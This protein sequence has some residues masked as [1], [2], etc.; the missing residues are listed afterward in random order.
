MNWNLAPASAGRTRAGRRTRV[1]RALVGVFLRPSSRAALL[2][3]VVLAFAS[4]SGPVRLLDAAEITLKNKL[5]LKGVAT[6]LKSLTVAEAKKKEDPDA[7]TI[8]P[9]L[10]ITTPLE[11]YFIPIRQQA[12][13]NNAVDLSK[14]DG[15]KVPQTKEKGG[16]QVIGAVHGYYEKP[17][18][19][20]SAGQRTL[21][22]EFEK[23]PSEV[24]QGVT[25]ITPDYIKI[26]AL[27]YLWETAMATSSM[28][29]ESLDAIIRKV[30]RQDNP[31]DRL[32]IATFYIQAGLY[33]SAERELEAIGKKF[34]TLSA[35]VKDVKVAL[36]QAF[37]QEILNEMKL[38]RAAGQ[39]QFVYDKSKAFPFENAGPTILR[40]VR[41]FTADYDKAHEKAEQ[42]IAQLGEL[43][44]QLKDDPRVKEIA[45]HRAEIYE[46]LNYSS[47]G[48]LE[49]YSKL[50]GDPLLKPDEKLALALSGWIVGS[51]NAVT[52]LDQALRFWQARIL[53]TEYLRTGPDADSER[54]AIL[55]KMEGLDGV[56]PERVAQMIPLL[57]PARD[58]AGAAPG[59]VVR[60]EV[61]GAQGESPAAYWVSLPLEYHPAH[62]YPLIIALHSEAGKALQEINGFWSGDETRIGQSERHG[63]IVIAPEYVGNGKKK[64]EY[65][66]DTHQ[67]VLDS[68]RDAQHRFSINANKVFL[69]GHSM[70]ADAVWDIGLAHP[71][72]FAG[73]IPISGGI[74]RYAKYYLENGRLLPI[75]AVA[76]ELD[77]NHFAKNSP[78]IT[79]MMQQNFDFIYNEYKGSGPESFYSEIHTLFDWMSLQSRPPLSKDVTGKTLRETDNRFFWLEFSNLKKLA[80][81]DWTLERPVV[82]PVAMTATI[83]PGNT[84]RV[85][86]GAEHV[87]L[88][89]TPGAGL[90]DFNKKLKV[91]I[92]DRTRFNN[93]VKPDMAAMLEHLRLSGD[94]QQIYWA[95]L[96]L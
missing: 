30:T 77:R 11:R 5:V 90:V 84:L 21:M 15:F 25:L 82:K 63:Y 96:D 86:G 61:G 23:G 49:A 65:G 64:F 52:G 2:A 9:I 94:H 17:G 22:L 31:D 14:R 1:I 80:P 13:I 57:E 41:D 85:S 26:S 33:E 37:A 46:R 45:P 59:K 40:E 36:E 7:I 92:V 70:G 74:D 38:R 55:K 8:Y 87:R 60:I 88:W 39:H 44:G 54:G 53:V 10:M 73:I 24:I 76:G 29:L 93:F 43:Q 32:K 20:T 56:G 81:V 42:I 83:T 50:S 91:N 78:S 27:N 51:D 66:A 62:S 3:A 48:R 75:F 47:L 12:E 18:P 89:L 4:W 34:P 28:P 71:H 58:A 67:I 35:K 6:P 72:L 19:F 68:L 95:M 79:K 16:S 69:A